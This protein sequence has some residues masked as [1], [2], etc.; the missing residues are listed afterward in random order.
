MTGEDR[1]IFM[2][3]PRRRK[4]AGL[5][6]ERNISR[7]RDSPLSKDEVGIC[8]SSPR[9]GAQGLHRLH[10]SSKLRNGLSHPH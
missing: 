7:V 4:G 10:V 2:A 8:H 3:E 1:K 5:R 9:K 6:K